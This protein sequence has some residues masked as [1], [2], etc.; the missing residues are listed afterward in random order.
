MIRIQSKRKAL[1]DALKSFWQKSEK[2]EEPSPPQKETTHHLIQKVVHSSLT[3]D[4]HTGSADEP[5]TEETKNTTTEEGGGQPKRRR[6]KKKRIKTW[7][8]KAKEL[9]VFKEVSNY[10]KL[11]VKD[12]LITQSK[13]ADLQN[14]YQLLENKYKV[15]IHFRPFIKVEGLSAQEFRNQRVDVQDYQ[16]IIFTSRL[17]IDHF[18]RLIH[19]MRISLSEST[20]FFCL[21]EQI[22]FYM[23]KYMEL[24]KR[25]ILWGQASEDF[26]SILKK[27]KNAKFLLPASDTINEKIIGILDDL[28]VSYTRV[29]IYK[30][31]LE[32][33]KDLKPENYDM[34]VFFTPIAVEALHKWF[35]KFKQD[36][37]RFAA[38]SL[39]T[40]N[41][42]KDLGYRIDLFAP[43]LEFPSMVDAIAHYLL[44]TEEK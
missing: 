39:L 22:A 6:K 1:P 35:P 17:A 37:T 3:E 14:P 20:K 16:G 38:Y 21:N 44:H 7:E 4:R 41:K 23:Q 32:N 25:R 33:I 2:K 42:L 43:T 36:K 34:M 11:P 19:E 12:I 28:N 10:P 8:E 13:P 31:V 30:T 18:F 26:K 29:D 9:P 15:N 5:N 40:A 24:R 27:N